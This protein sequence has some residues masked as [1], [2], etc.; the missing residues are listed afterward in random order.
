MRAQVKGNTQET[1]D[2]IMTRHERALNLYRAGQIELD[3][4]GQLAG[5]N[6]SDEIID[7]AVERGWITADQAEAIR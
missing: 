6:Y 4:L 7:R 5:H 1:E 3:T 2:N